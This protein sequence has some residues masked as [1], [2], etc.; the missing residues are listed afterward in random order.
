ME[1]SARDRKT[2]LADAATEIIGTEGLRGLTH[3]ATDARA[4]LPSGTCSYH[5]P[6]R[7]D[8]LAA[9]LHRIRD[10]ER[11]DIDRY[12]PGPLTPDLD[13]NLL[14]DGTT[15]TLAHWL[16]PA[17]I[18]S[19]ASMILRLDPSS[20]E[21]IESAMDSVIAEFH[22]MASAL[23]G[24]SHRARLAVALLDGILFDEL[25]RGPEQVD[26]DQ[27]RVQIT[28]VVRVALPEADNDP[29]PG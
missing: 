21:L 7:S 29:T 18:R 4:G 12:R 27:L 20:R 22:T 8:L 19:R 10:L 28:A 23:T 16:G 14:V 25:T 26:V 2:L 1:R 17:R 24:D 13:P 6:A 3:R 5:Y 11:A 9:V 15:A